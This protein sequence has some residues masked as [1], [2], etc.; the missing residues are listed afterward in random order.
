MEHDF[1]DLELAQ[2]A[3]LGKQLS[4]LLRLLDSQAGAVYRDSGIVVPVAVSSTLMAL[5]AF[6]PL[7]MADVATILKHP[8]QTIAQHLGILDKF[9]L[10]EKRSDP[11]DRRRSEIIL[12]KQGRAEADR[13]EICLSQIA[14]AYKAL[15]AEIGIDL[16]VVMLAAQEALTNA[17]LKARLSQIMTLDET[18]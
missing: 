14:L 4:D 1:F 11:N 16:S 2:T 8:H 7:S 15:Y 9:D 12:T 18:L 5:H 17:P 13:L 6:E 3:F 10:I